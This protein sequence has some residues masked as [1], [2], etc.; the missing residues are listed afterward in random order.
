MRLRSRAY[1]EEEAQLERIEEQELGA[2]PEEP[3]QSIEEKAFGEEEEA[4]RR[5]DRKEAAP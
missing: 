2:P 3:P 5:W 1:V 4:R